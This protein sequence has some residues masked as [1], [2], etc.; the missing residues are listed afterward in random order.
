[1]GKRGEYACQAAGDRALIISGG[2]G[3]TCISMKS[4]IIKRG[5]IPGTFS[6]GSPCAFNDNAVAKNEIRMRTSRI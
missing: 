3:M 4:K 1:M 2:S 6:Q 5:V